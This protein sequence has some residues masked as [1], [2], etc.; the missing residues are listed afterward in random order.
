MGTVIGEDRVRLETALAELPSRREL[1]PFEALRAFDAVARLGGV[2]RAAE[3]LCRD[4]GVV[5]RH[6]RTI[7][8]WT[9]TKLIRRT[10]GGAVLT[11]AGLAY[12]KRIAAAIDAIASATSELLTGGD[13][14]RLH[15][16]CMPGFALHW[17][18]PRISEFRRSHPTLDIEVRPADRSPEWLAY[19]MDVDIR[20]MATYAGELS[21]PPELQSC[22]FALGPVIPVAS[23]DYLAANPPVSTPGD[24]LNHH[25]LHEDSCDRW[26]NWF[27]AHGVQA[28]KDLAGPRLWQGHLTLDAARRGR[29]VAL[30]HFLVPDEDLKAGR[31]IEIGRDMPSFTPEALGVW[32]FTT[33]AE[34]WSAPHIARF[35]E[36]LLSRIRAEHPG[37]SEAA[38]S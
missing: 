5:S 4:H 12:H 13:G 36:W 29:G 32:Y 8:E 22:R 35:R 25:L 21:V 9:G 18:T 15:I 23:R 33:R 38:A 10:A 27:A 11:E 20:L 19:D 7:E 31:V 26:R 37:R 3:Y 16:R 34:R 2:R 28:P 17:L 6:L 24:L 30:L 1:P 14:H